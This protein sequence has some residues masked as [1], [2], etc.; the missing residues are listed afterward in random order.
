MAK[1][2]V[3]AVA[4][5]AAVHTSKALSLLLGTDVG[6]VLQA[7]GIRKV[8]EVFPAFS[9]D[10]AVTVVVMRITGEATGIACLVLPKATADAISEALA[11]GRTER[12][13]TMEMAR[14]TLMEV[15]NIVAG[16]YLTVLSNR[17]G[18]KPIVQVPE[19][20]S[21][22]FGAVGSQIIGQCATLST[23][24]LVTTVEF[25]FLPSKSRAY[26]LL[27]LDWEDSHRLFGMLENARAPMALDQV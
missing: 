20:A 14:S 8:A 21:D 24:V 4:S 17:V 13:Q 23:N 11:G 26:L 19:L 25:S 5:E 2:D 3:S 15:G 27:A 18:A 16:A 9:P 1:I 10:E 22:T 6:V 7:V 12:G